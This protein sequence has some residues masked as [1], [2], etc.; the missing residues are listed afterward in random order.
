ML[1]GET[2]DGETNFSLVTFHKEEIGVLYEGDDSFYT[3]TKESRLPN[4]KKIENGGN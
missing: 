4:I 1:K 2:E 3:T